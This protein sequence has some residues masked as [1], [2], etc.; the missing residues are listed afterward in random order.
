MTGLARLSLNTA[1]T[2][3][4]TLPQ[5]IDGAVRA[6]IP[7][8]GV[9]RDRVAEVGIERAAQLIADAGLR[10]SS[11]CRG[12]F[13]TGPDP[14]RQREVLADNWAA[15]DEAAT[16]GTKH[17]IMVVGGLPEDDRD[18]SGARQ[19]VA[20]RIAELV[21]H[22]AARGVRLV[23]EPMHPMYCADRGVISTL[24]QALDLAA[25][26]PPETVGVVVDT[27]HVWWDPDLPH[28]IARA[29]R[30]HRLASYQ[31]SD[32]NT[33]IAAD[34]LLSRG[35]MGDGHIDFNRLTAGVTAAGYTG[36]IEVEIFNADI[37][38]T[39][40]DTIL[41]TMIH[42]YRELVLPTL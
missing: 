8:L 14:A 27:F 15:I 7:A 5:A 28:Q 40:C 19:R 31:I 33:P 39:D 13:L 30:E 2:Q 17:L 4:W 36:D 9:W 23:L 6:G 34:A 25:P 37:W 3:H 12:G 26:H 42:R 24:R 22:A 1:T 11:L 16:L 35:M 18:L 20:E 38:N 32:W 10:V 29:G 21:D 41:T